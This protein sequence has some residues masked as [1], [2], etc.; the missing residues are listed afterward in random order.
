M[1]AVRWAA[2]KCK[3]FL[4]GLQDFQVI[5]DHNPL[6]PINNHRLNEIETPVKDKTHGT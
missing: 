6:M 3:M 1:L 5:T 4:M 2:N